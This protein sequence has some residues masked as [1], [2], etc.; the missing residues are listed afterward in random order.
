MNQP[1]HKPPTKRLYLCIYIIYP[2]GKPTFVRALQMYIDSSSKWGPD[3]E[4]RACGDTDERLT[5]KS[6]DCWKNHTFCRTDFLPKLDQSL[7]LN[8]AMRPTMVTK[9][10]PIIYDGLQWFTNGLAKISRIQVVPVT[11]C[12]FTPALRLT[13]LPTSTNSL[14]QFTGNKRMYRGSKPIWSPQTFV[15]CSRAV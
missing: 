5:F 15:Q 8:K 13:H 6:V 3:R 12:G 11:G 7:F 10:L 4:T 9:G 14:L 2:H 1:T